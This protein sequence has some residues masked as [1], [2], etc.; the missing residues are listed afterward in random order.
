[1]LP[2]VQ[3]RS[4]TVEH[5]IVKHL[6]N[7]FAGRQLQKW[8]LHSATCWRCSASLLGNDIRTV[9]IYHVYSHRSSVHAAPAAFPQASLGKPSYHVSWDTGAPEPTKK[10]EVP[11]S[12]PDGSHELSSPPSVTI[13][14]CARPVHICTF[15]KLLDWLAV[16]EIFFPS[17]RSAY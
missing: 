9:F 7:L 4:T 14:A 17:P 12:T 3:R 6:P 11:I 1:M 16:G 5:Q 10:P 8:R 15:G 13:S 2:H